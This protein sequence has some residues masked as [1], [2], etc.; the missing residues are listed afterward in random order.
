MREKI[1]K[2]DIEFD[3]ERYF[4]FDID[5]PH[6]SFPIKDC[7]K[8]NMIAD[9]IRSDLG[10]VPFFEFWHDHDEQGWYDFSVECE[11]KEGKLTD[12]SL[13]FRVENA[14]LSDDSQQSYKI[15]ISKEEA[16]TIG[17]AI[18]REVEDEIKEVAK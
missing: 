9:S 12:I 18:A 17:E 4:D 15:K 3:S 11:L 2:K 6:V 14:D 13:W 5:D 1:L 8:L 16:R 7:H 10:K